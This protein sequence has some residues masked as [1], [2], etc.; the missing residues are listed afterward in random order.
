MGSVDAR[1]TFRLL[2]DKLFSETV[3]GPLAPPSFGVS[4]IALRS[5]TLTSG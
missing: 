2:T 5:H 3:S 1:L 4:D